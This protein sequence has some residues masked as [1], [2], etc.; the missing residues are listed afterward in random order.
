MVGRADPSPAH[1]ERR[2][3]QTKK[4]G[5][6]RTPAQDCYFFFFAAFFTFFTAFLTAFFTAFFLAAI[7]FHLLLLIRSRSLV[8][9]LDAGPTS[10]RR[11]GA[12]Q[13]PGSH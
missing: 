10:K 11:A 2:C 8:H 3:H 7:P 4:P 1:R 12:P 9:G 6:I 13:N 5:L